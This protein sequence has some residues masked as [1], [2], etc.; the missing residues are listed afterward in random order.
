M[1][2]TL[3]C[4]LPLQ[5]QEQ[6]IELL[7]IFKTPILSGIHGNLRGPLEFFDDLPKVYI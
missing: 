2:L 1:L 4:F 5:S 7:L 3:L 6:Q